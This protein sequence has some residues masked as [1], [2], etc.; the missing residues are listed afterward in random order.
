MKYEIYVKLDSVW[1]KYTDSYSKPPDTESVTLFLNIIQE[2]IKNNEIF[3]EGIKKII[4][5]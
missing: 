1:S 3:S 2:V 4:E 5:T